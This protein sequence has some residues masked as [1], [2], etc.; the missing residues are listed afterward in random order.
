[1]AAVRTSAAAPTSANFSDFPSASSSAAADGRGPKSFAQAVR[2]ADFPILISGSEPPRAPDLR[3]EVQITLPEAIKGRTQ[4][5]LDLVAE[6]ECVTCGGSGNGLAR[7]GG[8]EKTRVIRSGRAVSP[9]AAAPVWCG[10]RRTLES[11]RYR[12]AR[13]DGTVLRLKGQGRE[14]AASP[15]ENGDLYLTIRI[16]TAS[17]VS[18]SR[19][20]ISVSSCRFWDFEAALGAEINRA[21]ARRPRIAQN[22]ARQP[23]RNA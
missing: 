12:R 20:A 11:G 16:E 9:L 7:G 2:R 6:D 5:A 22:S 4:S 1:V 13:P 19:A 21:H 10:N 3:A 14:G 23:D 8:R 18:S 17:G 15:R